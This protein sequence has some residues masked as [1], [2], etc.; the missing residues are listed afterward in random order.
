MFS[1]YRDFR[2]IWSAN[3][4]KLKS[5][6]L[7][8]KPNSSYWIYVKKQN[9]LHYIIKYH[10]IDKKKMWAVSMLYAF[11]VLVE[12][13]FHNILAHI[14]RFNMLRSKIFVLRWQGNTF[15]RNSLLLE[16][17]LFLELNTY[18]HG[19]RSC[20]SVLWFETVDTSPQNSLLFHTRKLHDIF[21]W[22]EVI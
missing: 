22:M 10:F 1:V 3:F 18:V 7:L 20:K 15:D 14:D 17:L 16:L 8:M 13:F 2:A 5:K 21:S 9:W 19:A 4:A 6:K 12:L 11:V